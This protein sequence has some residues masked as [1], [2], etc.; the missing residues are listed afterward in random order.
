MSKIVFFKYFVIIL[1]VI[2]VSV[3]STVYLI[4]KNNFLNEVV[5]NSNLYSCKQHRVIKKILEEKKCIE[6]SF[7]LGNF[8]NIK[9]TVLQKWI[10][11]TSKKVCIYQIAWQL[12]EVNLI[13][14]K[15]KSFLD[16]TN[17]SNLDSYK[18]LFEYRNKTIRL[19]ELIQ[20]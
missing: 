17:S 13:T 15:R 8:N 10:F 2:W 9:K 14:D 16:C 3:I 11:T 20:R 7:L 4:Q 18:E 1:V 6:W 5:Q 12:F 19:R